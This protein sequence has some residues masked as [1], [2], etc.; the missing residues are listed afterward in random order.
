MIEAEQLHARILEKLD[1]TREVEDE[2]LTG[3]IYQVLQ[4]AGQNEY[5]PLKIRT[6]LGKELFKYRAF[7]MKNM[8]SC[9]KQRDISCPGRNWKM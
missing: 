1:L 6:A 7:S 2:E 9:M 8:E 4:E 3:I 5:I